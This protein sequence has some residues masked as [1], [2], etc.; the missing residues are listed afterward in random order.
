MAFF[1]DSSFRNQAAA[2]LK[3]Y[4]FNFVTLD[5]QGYRPGSM[6]ATLPSPPDPQ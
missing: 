1:N 3:E 6:N 4:G 5:L 2:A